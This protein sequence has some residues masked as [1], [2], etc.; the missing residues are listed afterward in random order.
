MMNVQVTVPGTVVPISVMPTLPLMSMPNPAA[1]NAAAA[2][3]GIP[4]SSLGIRGP[5]PP[6]PLKESALIIDG[7]KLKDYIRRCNT[8]EELLRVLDRLPVTSHFD[9]TVDKLMDRFP[10]SPL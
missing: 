6:A 7:I 9:G 10:F 2:A 5:T 1:V 3:L 8:G 4:N